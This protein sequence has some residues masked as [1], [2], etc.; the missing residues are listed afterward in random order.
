MDCDGQFTNKR[1]RTAV[2]LL[3]MLLAVWSEFEVCS[4]YNRKDFMMCSV[5][6]LHTS[7]AR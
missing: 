2:A 6:F 4:V 3:T 1:H 5:G 7:S